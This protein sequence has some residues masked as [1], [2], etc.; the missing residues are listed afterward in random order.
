[1]ANLKWILV[2]GLL[3]LT[4]C[5][6]TPA[7]NP[8]APLAKA[9]QSICA[10]ESAVI[11]RDFATGAYGK[12]DMKPGGGFVLD[13]LPEHEPINPSPWYAFRVDPVKTGQLSITLHY[14]TAKHRYA[15][16]MST[17]GM[18]WANVPETETELVDEQHFVLHLP[19]TANRS[20]LVAAQPLF[21]AARHDAWIHKMARE[22]GL[23][24]QEIGSSM[25]GHPLYSLIHRAG[26]G[27]PWVVIVGRQHP[28][29]TTGADA[30]MP[31][32]ETL[33]ADTKLA[34]DF[35]ANYNLL[36]IP[37]INPDGVDEGHWRLNNGNVDLNRDWGPFTQAETKAVHKSI[38]TTLGKSELVLFLD[39]HSTWANL[40]YTQL[41]E[42]PTNP[43]MFAK[44]WL[45]AVHAKLPEGVYPFTREARRSTKGTTSKTFMYQTY[46]APS[47]TFEVGDE[48]PK[49]DID[50]AA[51]VFAQEAMKL[52]LADAKQG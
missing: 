5:A 23:A 11:S 37:M 16:K 46:G 29:E 52:L 30:L 42:E 31:F 33:L 35:R 36:L 24:L 15:P 51:P 28:P 48:T 50:I 2:A 49:S 9:P 38:D 18:H 25:A 21:P 45:D 41:D 19:V 4:A 14:P 7:W 47:M 20:F 6:G 8:H 22:H 32:V 26:P 1:M 44:Q 13:I 43:P 17:D 10:N 12:C 3:A 34:K 27:K 39:F 40:L